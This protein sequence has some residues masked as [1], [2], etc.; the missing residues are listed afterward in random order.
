MNNI[1]ELSI[2]YINYGK[3]WLTDNYDSFKGLLT[4]MEIDETLTESERND[5]KIELNK[6]EDIKNVTWENDFT[7]YIEF[8]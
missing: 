6:N 3:E 1:K 5:L 8:K 2:K 4:G 7:L